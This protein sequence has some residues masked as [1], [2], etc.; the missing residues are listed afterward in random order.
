[1]RLLVL[2]NEATGLCSDPK[3]NVWV[4][5]SRTSDRETQVVEY[6]H[7]GRSPIAIMNGPGN[8]PQG[9]SVDPTSGDLAVATYGGG[10]HARTA[11]HVLVFPAAP[12]FPPKSY[13]LT[14]NGHYLSCAYD[15][16]G[17]LY[18]DGVR[19]RRAFIFYELVKGDSE[20]V[21]VTLD[22]TFAAPGG[23]RWDGSHVAVADGKTNV[24]YQFTIA[25]DKG[26]SVGT[27][28]LEN[29]AS[30]E[31]RFWIEGGT[32]VAAPLNLNQFA[33]W[34]YPA[35]GIPSQAFAGANSTSFTVSR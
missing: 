1:V 3:G 34:N 27:T 16:A 19:N 35:G 24:I 23:I 6:A 11:G 30:L 10:A 18:V 15:A 5:T 26:T 9:C 22:R 12:K 29:A 21:P 14:Q 28:T 20:F 8:D 32:V 4:T 2:G 31:D 33:Y 13:T 7:G 17:N 25:D